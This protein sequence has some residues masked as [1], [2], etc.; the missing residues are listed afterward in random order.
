MKSK[1]F[2]PLILIA[3]LTFVNFSI[4]QVYGQTPQSKTEKQQ[5]VKYTCPDHPEIVQDKPGTCPKDGKKLVEKK[6]M[7][8]GNMKTSGDSTKMKMKHDNSKMMHDSTAMKDGKMK[9]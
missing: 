9:M 3:G 8:K 2:L 5:A 1:F 6:D 7:P 4:S